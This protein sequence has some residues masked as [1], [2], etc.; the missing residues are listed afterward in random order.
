MSQRDAHM[1][2]N[3]YKIPKLK[4]ERN[5]VE[6]DFPMFTKEKQNQ[7]ESQKTDM[8]IKDKKHDLLL[9]GT[10]NPSIEEKKTEK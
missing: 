5:H 7:E 6:G 9:H 10:V 2:R 1:N 4:T 3:L 8:D